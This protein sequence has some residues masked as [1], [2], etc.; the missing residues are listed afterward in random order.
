MRHSTTMNDA[1]KRLAE[2]FDGWRLGQVLAALR[3]PDVSHSDG[4]GLKSTYTARV[5]DEIMFRVVKTLRPL[6]WWAMTRKD[7]LAFWFLHVGRAL[8]NLVE[9]VGDPLDV[10][11][12]WVSTEYNAERHWDRRWAEK[13]RQRSGGPRAPR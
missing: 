9:R 5:S 13:E 12:V 6:T 2:V 4:L 10:V 8:Y 3:G 11:H 1:V 7:R